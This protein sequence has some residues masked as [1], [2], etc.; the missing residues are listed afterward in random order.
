MPKKE[1]FDKL[2][3][4]LLAYDEEVVEKVAK[5]IIDE[6]LDPV[7]ALAVLTTTVREIGN[8][9]GAGELWL[10]ELMMAADATRAG[11]AILTPAI[12]S[13]EGVPTLGTFV[14][15]TVKGDLHDIGKTIVGTMLAAAGF[16]VVDLGIDVA[17]SAF[18]EAAQKN[19]AD[20][21]GASALMLTTIPTQKD[22]IEYFEAL[23]IRGKYKIMVGGGACGN[24]YAKKIGA[25]AYAENA[26]EAVKIA[27][28]LVA[29]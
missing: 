26:I 21:V 14:I 25:D 7:E 3:E 19:N 22:V 24:E 17:P 10:P 29:K 9:Y 12:P 23:G 27:T 15:G 6:G 4:G 8:K 13:G 1:A 16:N 2:K 5:E 28:K 20:I 18:A 11:S